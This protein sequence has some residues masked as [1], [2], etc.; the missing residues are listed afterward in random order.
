[1]QDSEAVSL[2]APARARVAVGRRFAAL[3]IAAVVVD[4][5]ACGE[6]ITGQGRTIVDDITAR[7]HV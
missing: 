5:W 7:V 6:D 4:A 2:S 1:L 3:P